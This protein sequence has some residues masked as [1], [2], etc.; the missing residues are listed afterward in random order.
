M[1]SS[2]ICVQFRRSAIKSNEML[3]STSGNELTGRHFFHDESCEK[4][5][6]IAICPGISKIIGVV[7]R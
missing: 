1:R 3:N 7:D 4:T 6:P 5:F 2:P